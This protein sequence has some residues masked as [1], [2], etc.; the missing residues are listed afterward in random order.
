MK[1]LVL[2]LFFI[3][4]GMGLLYGGE[5]ATFES[6]Y[7]E[8]LTVG[9]LLSAIFAVLAGL[10]IFFTGGTASPIVV[11]IG[12]WIGSLAGL[13]GIAA[14]NY[15]LALIGF[16]SLATGG[17]GV[18]G[19]VAILTAALTFST[20]VVIDYTLSTAM[21]T[22]SH[23]RFV[24]QSKK[25]ITLPIPQNEEGS[26]AYEETVEYLKAHIL[27]EK[28]L[29][30][31]ENQEVLKNTLVQFA[32][33]TDDAE[34]KIKDFVLKSYLHFVLNEYDKAKSDA[35]TAID[36]ARKEKIR[37]T[38]PA[39]IYAT[40]SFY[41]KNFD[42]SS[43]TKNYFRYSILAEPDNKL[44][45]LMFAVYL[46][47][48]MYRMN[49]DEKLGVNSL[50]TIRDIGFEVK[51]NDLKSQ[52]LVTILTRYFM[53]LKIEQQKILA[54]TESEN[55]TIKE[56][57]KT[58]E[59]VKLAY[60]HYIRLLEGINPIISYEPIKEKIE[61]NDELGNLYVVYGKYEESVHYL[62]KL[63]DDL[64]TYQKNLSEREK[65]SKAVIGG[66][67]YLE[68]MHFPWIVGGVLLLL[69]LMFGIKYKK[70]GKN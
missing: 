1:R 4:G 18:A 36:F 22:Y 62:K 38:L 12:S 49:D 23:Q 44:I 27:K 30:T 47:R 34:E 55:D 48:L 50:D 67:Q 6:F 64:E 40:S 65:K 52:V 16:G 37:R 45:P 68:Y 33:V 31:E 24:E 21:T 15:G 7:V 9:W 29:F 66:T 14:T 46:E 28:P 11:G 13:S 25:M 2:I 58:V 3:I 10:A 51:E 5:Y 70:R 53:R 19:G 35:T 56:N 41:E 63:I 26:D 57:P 20:E 39:F 42:F 60:E 61:Q 43:I 69:L 32:P 17:L 8:S 54:L 59:V